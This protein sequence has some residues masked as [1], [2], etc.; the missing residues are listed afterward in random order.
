MVILVN[1]VNTCS[2]TILN[3]RKK[4]KILNLYSPLSYVFTT[5]ES[6][7]ACASYSHWSDSNQ[8]SDYI[9]MFVFLGFHGFFATETENMK[10]AFLGELIS[11][12]Y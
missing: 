7:V 8:G 11:L 2:R 12:P 3:N 4:F 6:L 1:S 10:H 5:Q 9:I